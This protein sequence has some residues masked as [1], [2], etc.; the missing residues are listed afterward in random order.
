MSSF[1][2]ATKPIQFV[3]REKNEG[4]AAAGGGGGI[5]VAVDTEKNELYAA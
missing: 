3:W 4:E 1:Q 5:E 2:T